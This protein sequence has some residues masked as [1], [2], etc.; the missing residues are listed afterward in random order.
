MIL[1]LFGLM[2]ALAALQCLLSCKKMDL[3]SK[4]TLLVICL[5][6]NTHGI[7]RP[8]FCISSNQQVS[9]TLTATTRTIK[10]SVFLMT[11]TSQKIILR[12]FWRGSISTLS[13]RQTS[14][15]SLENLMLV[16]MCHTWSIKSITTIWPISAQAFSPPTW[17]EWWWVTAAPTGNTIPLPRKLSCITGTHLSP[18][19]FTKSTWPMNATSQDLPKSLSVSVLTSPMSSKVLQGPWTSTMS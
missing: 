12:S 10:T 11:T 16:F 13:L 7:R 9:D 18:R 14:F 17:R 5:S 8:L 1:W 15:T 6:T 3:T 19:T 2:V 4:M